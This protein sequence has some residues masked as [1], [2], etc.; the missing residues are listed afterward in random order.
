MVPAR[1]AM[2]LRGSMNFL[3]ALASL[4]WLLRIA[5]WRESMKR[6]ASPLCLM[7][8]FSICS[9]PEGVSMGSPPKLR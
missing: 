4:V 8:K 6:T 9:C 1:S 2:R 5:A 7:R 3:T